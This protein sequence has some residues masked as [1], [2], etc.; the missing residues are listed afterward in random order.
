MKID[1]LI[2]GL[3]TLIPLIIG[4]IWYNPKVFGSAWMK[5]TGITEEQAKNANMFKIFGLTIVFSFMIAMIMNS[6]VIH[7]YGL[8]SLI[9]DDPNALKDPAAKSTIWFNQSMAEYG[10]VFRTFKHGAFHG[11]LISLMLVLPVI[12]TNALFERKGAKYIFINWGYW[13]I[14]LMLMGGTICQWAG[15]VE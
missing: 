10:T 13:A 3:A 2:V 5:A 4:F 8:L 15:I 7:Q 12:G 9:A 11:F 6:L 1:F 14:S